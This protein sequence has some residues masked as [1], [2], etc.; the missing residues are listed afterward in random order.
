MSDPS[1]SQVASLIGLTTLRASDPSLN[2]SGVVLGQAEASDGSTGAQAFEVDAGTIG[3]TGSLTYWNGLTSTSTPNDG[4]IGT[5]STHA[6]NQ[7]AW[8][9]GASSGIAPGIT[10]V[11]NY[12]ADNFPTNLTAG[13]TDQVVNMSF[14]YTGSYSYDPNYD[15][16]ALAYN[17]V[18]VAAAGASG[19]ISSPSAAYNVISADSSLVA[20]ATGAA[21]D[22]K[23]GPDISAPQSVT[24][25]D[26]SVVSGAAVILV[27]A[28]NLASSAYSSADAVDFRTVK[29]LLLN[30]A[31]K[32]A[33]YY[34]TS[35]APTAADPLNA[36]YGSGV[37][38]I[39][40]AVTELRGGEFTPGATQSVTLGST[41]YSAPTLSPLAASQ[42]WDL[43]SLTAARGKDEIASYGLSLSAGA[44]VISTVT[45]AA[46][47]SNAIN[48][49]ALD[50]YSSAGPFVCA[51]AAPARHEQQISYM[52]GTAGTYVLQVRLSGSSHGSLTDTYAV[53]FAP[54]ATVACFCAGTRIATAR[55]DVAV[56]MLRHGDLVATAQGLRPL[57]FLGRARADTTRHPQM[58]PVRIAAGAFGERRPGRD[59][60]LS[61]EHCV[62]LRDRHGAALVPVHRLR[63]GASIRTE[64]AAGVV[65]YYHVG[66]AH[67]AEITADGLP[68]ESYL[69]TGNRGSFDAAAGL[70]PLFG[71]PDAA[72]PHGREA[73]LAP[74][75][76]DGA[77]LVAWHAA[78]RA[79]AEALGARRTIDPAPY[80]W[81]DGRGVAPRRRRPGYA[82]FRLPAGLRRVVLRP[83]SR[84]PRDAD[85]DGP[86]HR[87]LGLPLTVLRLDGE[88]IDEAGHGGVHPA[89]RDG[90][91]CWRWTDGAATLLLPPSPAPT[92]LEIWWIAGWA[93]YW[94]G[95]PATTR[96]GEIHHGAA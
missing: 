88:P 42:G 25:R 47:S 53:A 36:M 70:H 18:F 86:D 52:P 63:N 69:D 57:R 50:L 59:L 74:L 78:L 58:S 12:F 39:D 73:A 24:S 76:I 20:Q 90:E 48:H 17:T 44:G 13:I 54:L 41:A 31:V 16:A 9:Y 26:S 93:R 3:Y 80:L 23:P 43:A 2:G 68:V 40:N 72:L 61:P 29:T 96:A 33:D 10:Q 67:H 15:A 81:L 14:T 38:N 49:F 28:G 85:P 95:M 71:E 5:Y 92:T 56:E 46:N 79:R 82:L 55:G 64:P 37:V 21:S 8:M 94:V 87:R 83:R 30:G 6:T 77:R 4:I 19:A 1:Y 62:V 91:R 34:T 27:Q 22:G 75:V 11:D 51:P 35:Y 45:W 84:G 60:R 66:L 89:E 65:A 32:P 7:A